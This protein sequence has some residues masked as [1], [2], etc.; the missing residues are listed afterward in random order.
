MER[1]FLT[2]MLRQDPAVAALGGEHTFSVI[3]YAEGA[4]KSF[5]LQET[6][7]FAR[8]VVSDFVSAT[9]GACRIIFIGA[10][11]GKET[12]HWVV[13]VASKLP[14]SRPEFALMDSYNKVTNKTERAAVES[15]TKALSGAEDMLGSILQDRIGKLSTLLEQC[16]KSGDTSVHGLMDEKPAAA[17]RND[18]L[19][20]V[21]ILSAAGA[22]LPVDVKSKLLTL[23]HAVVGAVA[24]GTLMEQ[25]TLEPVANM[26]VVLQKIAQSVF[27]MDMSEKLLPTN[28]EKALQASAEE[29]EA[30]AAIEKAQKRQEMIGQ[31]LDFGLSE[32]QANMAV[33]ATGAISIQVAVEWHYNNAF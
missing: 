10:T 29:K 6:V 7:D 2:W 18:E 5:D 9:V 8:H 3:E 25:G 11:E 30:L 28:V 4:V 12:G 20:S 13:L 21:Q 17:W 24:W 19:E 27:G 16:V 1:S 26:V 23:V 32:E 31:M 33:D 15:L 14:G 22:K